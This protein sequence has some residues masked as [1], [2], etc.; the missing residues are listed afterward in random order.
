MPTTKIDIDSMIAGRELDKLVEE[1]V[2]GGDME[3]HYESCFSYLE[4]YSTY[5]S[6]AWAMVEKLTS[7]TNDLKKR[8]GF[9]L[10]TCH[11][12]FSGPV[13]YVATFEFIRLVHGEEFKGMADTAPLAICKAALKA[14]MGD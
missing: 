9:A 10:V 12:D 13:S 6:A 14:V 2:M 3:Y 1:H 7:P 5:I 4:L 8:M 11:E